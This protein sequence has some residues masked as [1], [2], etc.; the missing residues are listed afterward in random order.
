LV[1]VEGRYNFLWL[2]PQVWRKVMSAYRQ[3]WLKSELTAR[4]PGSA[5]GPTLGNEYAWKYCIFYCI[6]LLQL[7]RHKVH[8]IV[9]ISNAWNISQNL[10][11][12]YIF[13]MLRFI[14]HLYIML[15]ECNYWIGPTIEHVLGCVSIKSGSFG[16]YCVKYCPPSLRV[17]F[18]ARNNLAIGLYN[19]YQPNSI[20][21]FW[22]S[23]IAFRLF[24]LVQRHRLLL[25]ST[26]LVPS[27]Y[28]L[29]VTSAL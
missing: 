7:M 22:L 14:V 25:Q 18:L 3:G 17:T 2:W 9:W 12:I 6:V 24:N 19:E 13:Y 26:A 27:Y 1:L 5:P 11:N 20:N 23:V 15:W 16:S 10:Q 4:T 21:Y 28:W 8:Y 29:I